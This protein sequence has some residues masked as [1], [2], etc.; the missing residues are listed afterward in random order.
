MR[1]IFAALAFVGLMVCAG[2]GPW[3]GGKTVAVVLTYDDALPSQL[4][5]AASQLDAAGLKGTFFLTGSGLRPET[6][7]R[8]RALSANGHEL[9][10]HTVFHACPKAVYPAP[11][12]NTT[13][14]Y[15][16]DAMLGE[17]AVMNNLLTAIDGKLQHAFATPCGNHVVANGDYLDTLRRGG[18]VRYTRAVWSP[19]PAGSD[20][21]DVAS[22]WFSDKATGSDMIKA[23][24]AAEKTGG[25]VV[26]GFHGVGGDYL[27]TSAKAHAE[28]LAYLKAHAATI[29][30]AP[31]STVLDYAT[32]HPSK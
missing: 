21:M 22:L 4:D 12:R 28:L 27:T 18:L 10:N 9:G 11:E 5:I 14:A 2:A 3:P 17:I 32:A 29:W 8:W 26:F 31:F 6:I 20:G 23:V 13:E 24:E 19:S 30:V 16:V 25:L 15:T 1:T 7:A